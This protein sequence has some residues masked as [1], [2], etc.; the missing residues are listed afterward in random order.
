MFIGLSEG[1]KKKE[2]K[3]CI[4]GVKEDLGEGDKSGFPQQWK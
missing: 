2:G 1:D 3:D 4:N